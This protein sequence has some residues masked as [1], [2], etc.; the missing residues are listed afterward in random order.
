MKTLLAFSAVFLIASAAIA[1]GAAP[2]GARP[3]ASQATSTLTVRNSAYGRVLFDGRGKAL[4]AFTRDPKGGKSRCYGTCASAWPVYLAKGALRAGSGVRQR[5]V[6]STVRRDGRRQVTY[7]GRPLYYYVGDRSAG[8]IR[9]QNV[10]EFGGT[11]LVVRPSG[12]L[13][14]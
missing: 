6:G 12:Q 13:V 7:D 11:W 5:L 9:C 8:E 14:R 1:I 4:Y 2:V 3:A 10:T